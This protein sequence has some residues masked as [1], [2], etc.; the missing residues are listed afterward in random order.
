MTNAKFKEQSA[1]VTEVFPGCFSNST[2]EVK[3]VHSAVKSKSRLK[4]LDV[5]VKFVNIRGGNLG[6]ICG[7]EVKLA[8]HCLEEVADKEVH[9]QS[10]GNSVC[11]CHFKCPC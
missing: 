7:D 6:G 3:A 9:F 1:V 8:F 4:V 10:V 5:Y 11:L 2:I